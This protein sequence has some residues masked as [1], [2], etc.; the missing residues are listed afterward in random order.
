MKLFHYA[1]LGGACCMLAGCPNDN[2]DDMMVAPAPAK[3]KFEVTIT[4]ATAGQPFSPL[5]LIAHKADA[6][7]WSLGESVS[8]GLEHVAETGNP[9]VFRTALK[10]DSTVLMTKEG[11]G[12]AD[13]R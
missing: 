11:K 13:G 12:F 2:D 8:V 1:L 7:Y 10:T 4:N 9:D 5:T 3:A 6:K